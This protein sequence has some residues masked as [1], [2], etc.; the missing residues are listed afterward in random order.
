MFVS[1]V[2]DYEVECII[3][4][5]QDSL[6]AGINYIAETVIKSSVSFINK[7]P[8]AYIYNLSFQT[9]IFPD[10]LKLAKITPTSIFKRDSKDD[11]KNYR[12][13]SVLSVFFFLKYWKNWCIVD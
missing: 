4:G 2:K 9:G 12:P 8:L 7:K 13:I 6:S 5:L 3:N 11:I 10:Y 1:P